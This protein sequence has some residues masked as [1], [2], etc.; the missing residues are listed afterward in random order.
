M[1]NDS[2][3][4]GVNPQNSVLINTVGAHNPLSQSLKTRTAHNWLHDRLIIT[5]RSCSI[6]GL[7]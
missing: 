3:V 7:G 1:R 2:V 5:F 6:Y 4:T